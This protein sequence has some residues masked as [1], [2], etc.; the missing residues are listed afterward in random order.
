MTLNTSRLVPTP[1]RRA[2]RN[3]LRSELGATLVETALAI[4]LLLTFVVGIMEGSL[5]LY[6]YHFISN[7]AREGV[8]Y[9][10]VRGGT[11]SNTTATAC[12]TYAS[13]G[14]TATSTNVSDY[15]TSLAFPGINP[16]NLKVTTNWYS[17]FGGTSN[18]AYNTPS[19][20]VQVQVQY[21]FP[22]RVPFVPQATWTM[23]SQSEMEISQ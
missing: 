10:I 8:R 7:A 23:S 22:L 1:I 9:A 20:I 11:W 6:S 2:L 4:T 14:C 16:A 21:K 19:N 5:A 3:R 15:V 13:A 12:T 17:T 18:V